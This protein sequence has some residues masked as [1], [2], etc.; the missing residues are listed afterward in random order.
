MKAQRIGTGPIIVPHMDG[1]MGDNINGPSLIRVPEWIPRPLGRYYLYFAH[2][3]GRYIRL[4]YADRV[5]GP[6]RMHEPGVLPIE[7]TGFRGHVASPD[8]HVDHTE[9]RIRLY[10]HGADT[11]SDQPGPQHTRVACSTDGVQFQTRPENLGPAYFRVFDWRGWRIALAMPGQLYRSYDGLGGFE[12]GPVL[13]DEHMRH[14]ALLLRD[15]RLLV[16]YSRAGDEPERILLSEIA[17]TPDWWDWREGPSRALLAPETAHEGADL[18]MRPSRRGIAS[19]R[20]RELRDPAIHV[21]D[22]T[23]YL[24]YCVAGESGI[25]LARLS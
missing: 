20:V 2:H 18:A 23:C 19:G 5:T 11:P 10:F 13:F 3:D 4:A 21:E 25:A 12:P 9:R 1:R 15:D 17:L 8:V 6:W 16:F 22:D 7:T 14:S 24:L